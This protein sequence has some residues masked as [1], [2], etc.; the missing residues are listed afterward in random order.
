MSVPAWE[1]NDLIVCNDVSLSRTNRIRDVLKQYLYDLDEWKNRLIITQK[2]GRVID[3]FNVYNKGYDFFASS[4]PE[5]FQIRRKSWARI[6]PFSSSFPTMY[7]C[8]L[9]RT[10]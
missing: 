3:D 4:G 10:R 5:Y 6:W 8:K 2:D 1:D 7:F 9:V